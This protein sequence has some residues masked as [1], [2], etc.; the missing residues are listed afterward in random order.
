MSNTEPINNGFSKL[1][2]PVRAASG[3]GARRARALDRAVSNQVKFII[4]IIII[5]ENQVRDWSNKKGETLG[6]PSPGAWRHYCDCHVL[7]LAVNAN[8]V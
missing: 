8:S 1:P 7:T 4:I 3:Q 5:L 6:N 2:A